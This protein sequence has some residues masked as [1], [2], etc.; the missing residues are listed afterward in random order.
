M[1]MGRLIVLEGIDGAGKATQTR[2]LAKSIR[3][4]G[5][6]VSVFTSPRYDIPTG[7]LVRRALSGEFGDFVRMHP[8]MS[9][10]P[11]LVDF[12]AWSA[13]VRA[14]LR[15]GDVICDRY[16]QSTL[17]YHAAKF[18][19]AQRARFLKEFSRIAFVSLR[20]PEP[21]AIFLL[22]VP[23]DISQGLMQ[24]KKKD[25]YESNIAYQKRVA[26]VYRTLARGKSWRTIA[27][28]AGG[29]M[30]SRTQIHAEIRRALGR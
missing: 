26:S 11:Y 23:V 24:K 12:A 16:V 22:D 30:R 1:R 5:K 9:A 7:K 4:E 21:D 15:V 29:K 20:L 18:D 28:A 2:L 3:A 14:A 10:L 6:K 17:A 27:C 8:Y 13:D 25:Q 19:G